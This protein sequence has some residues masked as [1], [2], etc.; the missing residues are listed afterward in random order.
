[1]LALYKAPSGGSWPGIVSKLWTY[2]GHRGPTCKPYDT[3]MC[4]FQLSTQSYHD[5]PIF[6]LQSSAIYLASFKRV[7][8]VHSP[9]FCHS[10]D[11]RQCPRAPLCTSHHKAQVQL[12]QGRFR[13]QSLVSSQHSQIYPSYDLDYHDSG[14]QDHRLYRLRIRA[15]RSSKV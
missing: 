10:S 2:F 12:I 3:S 11:V 4:P 14:C 6:G 13:V 9:Q 15:S 7:I 1:M 8:Y 5:L